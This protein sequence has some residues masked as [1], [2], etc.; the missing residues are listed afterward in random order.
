MCE[1]KYFSLKIALLNYRINSL[2]IL[3]ITQEMEKRSIIYLKRFHPPTQRSSNS[4]PIESTTR[5]KWTTSRL[6]AYRLYPNL[7]NT[8]MRYLFADHGYIQLCTQ[9][10][11]VHNYMNIKKIKSA[12]YH[13]FEAQGKRPRERVQIMGQTWKFP[14]FFFFFL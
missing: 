14:V 12:W 3:K 1:M 10:G 8:M 13:S 11:T 2:N 5:T 6:N 7:H 4:N 9:H